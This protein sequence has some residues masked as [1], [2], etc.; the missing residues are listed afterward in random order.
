MIEASRLHK[1]NALPNV[2]VTPHIAAATEHAANNIGDMAAHNIL[3]YLRGEI[4]DEAS[5]IN[6]QVLEHSNRRPR[7]SMSA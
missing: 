2:I 1:D 3:N 4:F 5:V 7:A 6:P